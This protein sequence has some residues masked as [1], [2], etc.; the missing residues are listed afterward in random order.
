MGIFDTI[1]NKV[2][3]FGKALGEAPKNVFEGAKEAREKILKPVGQFLTPQNEEEA[4]K[5]G[6][7]NLGT[8]DKPF[9]FDPTGAVGSVQNASFKL[10]KRVVK[11]GIKRTNVINN[12]VKGLVENA[13]EIVKI[14]KAGNG[15]IKITRG[16]LE[17]MKNMKDLKP[18]IGER[19]F[20]NPIRVFE[21]LGEP[22]KELFYRPIKVAEHIAVETKNIYNKQFKEVTKGLN[23]KNSERIMRYALAQEKGTEKILKGKKPPTLNEKE[24]QAYEYIR[25]RY[26]Q[27]LDELN[28]ARAIVGKPEINK[29]DNYMTHIRDLNI[30]EQM[31]F[32]PIT[33]DIEKLLANKI[34]RNTT[35][36]QFAKKRT[37]ALDQVEMDA[38]NV[39]SKYQEKAID[40][41]KL[42][43]AIAKVRELSRTII[44]DTAPVKVAKEFQSLAQEARKYK[45]AEEFVKAQ[46]TPVYH[47]TNYETFN[48]SKAVSKNGQ[49]GKG[50]YFATDKSITKQY[51]NKTV[52][53]FLDKN[54]LL[55]I[56]EPLTATQKSS[57]RKVMGKDEWDWSKNPTGEF[58]W[59]RL[60]LTRKSPEEL[61]KKAGIKGIEHKQYVKNGENVNYTIF[62]ES[63]IKTKSQLTDIWKQTNE[64]VGNKFKLIDQ[65]PNAF[66]YISEWTDYVAGQKVQS[67]IPSVLENVLSKLNKNIAFSTLSFNIRSALIQPSAIINSVTELGVKNTGTGI[68][69]LLAGKGAF[70]LKNSNVL[71]GRQFETAM[72]DI[73]NSVFGKGGRA[74]A[75]IAELGIKP[76]QVLDSLTAQSTWLG[77]YN[78][79]VSQLGKT[80]K[81]A[82]NYADD[83]VVKTQASAARS[84]VAKIQRNTLGKVATQFQTFVINDF[85]RIMRDVAG[86][87]NANM[88]KEEAIK[89]SLTYITGVSLWNYLNEDVLGIPTPFPRPIKALREKGV[90]DAAQEIGG[91]IPV[92]GGGIRYGGVPLGAAADLTSQI[93][94]KV[95]GRY[96]PASWW[97]IAGKAFGVPGTSQLKKTIKAVDGLED[98]YRV[99]TNDGKR[100]KIKITDPIDKVR[101]LLL[102]LYE[103]SAAKETRETGKRPKN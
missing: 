35:A 64:T 6:M 13:D 50:I 76:L 62:D 48:P 82:Y 88:T 60:E 49:Y 86:F 57:L 8:E 33:D 40:H 81:A 2:G 58:V 65:A 38:F 54:S 78:R 32:S 5:S 102:G 94:E 99:T 39:F 103:T 11:E 87:G 70:A 75:K 24:V 46:G 90:V 73:A 98:G 91:Q 53:A 51:G 41:I 1:V 21:E 34:H 31:G 55:K 12:A 28:E 43:P 71:Q 7:V 45:S 4:R 80:G 69:E 3:A 16:E 101:A 27:L 59:Q 10:T 66:K 77:A 68:K 47:G 17:L 79:A 52:E 29:V 84:D 85:N 18:S 25:S 93:F 37:G 19:Y 56:D 92:V 9:Y 23:S 74:K 63:A 42:T 67:N 96:T 89:K 61:L 22:I 72:Q 100:I 20:Q 36:F 26:D 44:P 14:R 15:S 97:E 95:N 83:V 30:L